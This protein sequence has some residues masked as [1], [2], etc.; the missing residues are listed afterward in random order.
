MPTYEFQC[1]DC[2]KRFSLV[3][4]IAA[5]TR[6]PTCPRCRSRRTHQ[7]LGAFYAKTIKKS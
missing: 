1:D 3:R 6:A 5:A 2:R 4:P 7:I